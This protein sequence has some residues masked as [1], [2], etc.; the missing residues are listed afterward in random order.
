MSNQLFSRHNLKLTRWLKGQQVNMSDTSHTHKEGDHSYHR[1]V[2]TQPISGYEYDTR[3]H[4]LRKHS[5]R[6]RYATLG[7][8]GLAVVS[9]V[10]WLNN[11]DAFY[12]DNHNLSLQENIANKLAQL[13]QS[14]GQSTSVEVPSDNATSVAT[15]ESTEF[16]EKIVATP[17]AW[18]P[19]LYLNVKPGDTLLVIFERNHLNLDDMYQILEVA[20]YADNLHSLYP[21][22]EMRVKRGTDDSVEELFAALDLNTEL[23]IFKNDAGFGGEIMQ[24]NEHS[25]RMQIVTD[26]K[27][28]AEF[29]GNDVVI[30]KVQLTEAEMKSVTNPPTVTAK[31]TVKLSEQ[32]IA[33]ANKDAKTATQVASKPDA[34]TATQAAIKPAVTPKESKDHR[35]LAAQE[36]VKA[37]RLKAIEETNAKKAAR[38]VAAK[39]AV[40]KKEAAQ[41]A[42]RLAA[43]EE[44][45]EKKRARP[46]TSTSTPTAVIEESQAKKAAR[47]A[48]AEEAAARKAARLAAAEEIA[49]QKAERIAAAE[50]AA[51][52]RKAE[53]AA[54]AEEIAAQKAARVA[55]KQEQRRKLIASMREMES[56]TAAQERAESARQTRE[57]TASVQ[58]QRA[59]RQEVNQ[60]VAT[61]RQSFTQLTPRPAAAIPSPA[62][63]QPAHSHRNRAR[64]EVGTT[65]FDDVDSRYTTSSDPK[66]S[67]VLDSARGL[68]GT[69]Y[70]FGGTTPKGFDCSGFV[71][72]NAQKAG[73]SLPRTAREQY[74]ATKAVDKDELKPGDLV[75]FNTRGRGIGHVGIYV[76]DNKFIHAPN[77]RKDVQVTSLNNKYYKQRYVRG[78]RF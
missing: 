31:T 48:A 19:W 54:A 49:A 17:A 41:K 15:T 7:V 77:R 34:K 57:A 35:K 39:E 44:A 40:A 3:H 38:I 45:A 42:A 60:A 67:K 6:L 5:H 75:F 73:A 53:Q 4:G 47:I 56:R 66:L 36:A 43:A 33:K 11:S 14:L 2:L 25:G 27:I 64:A 18:S 24:F 23:H 9:L 21:N 20:E 61:V 1:T 12:Q 8:G 28:L 68:L 51:A 30:P 63:E 37:A 10:W 78:G 74:S 13:P 50:E 58:P 76:G 65:V 59:V 22:Q 69:P 62:I 71:R 72:Y 26:P 16:L 52:A 70:R 29:G 46:A 32:E 55:E